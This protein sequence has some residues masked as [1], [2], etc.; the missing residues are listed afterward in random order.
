MEDP[1]KFKVKDSV[2]LSAPLK[3]LV[4]WL[5][6]GTMVLDISCGPV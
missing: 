3:C 6:A 2:R 1:W 4:V 5:K